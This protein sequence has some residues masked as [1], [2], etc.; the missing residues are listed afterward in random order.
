[1]S[2]VYENVDNI[3]LF[4]A[5]LFKKWQSKIYLFPATKLKNRVGRY[6]FFL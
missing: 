6:N 2:F 5:K 1:M 3:D 4:I